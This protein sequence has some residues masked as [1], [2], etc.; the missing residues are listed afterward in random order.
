MRRERMRAGWVAPAALAAGVGLLAGCDKAEP[1]TEQA[2]GNPTGAAPDRVLA[3]NERPEPLERSTGGDSRLIR[4]IAADEWTLRLSRAPG[5][6]SEQE[7]E[8]VRGGN[9]YWSRIGSG[10]AIDPAELGADAS[11]SFRQGAD[12]TGDGRPN[13]LVR[14]RRRA[15]T[16]DLFLVLT[17]GD[18]V[19]V[20]ARIEAAGEGVGF[21]DRD[22][23][24]V[25]EFI[26]RDPALGEAS[27]A[28]VLAME[29]GEFRVSPAHMAA[30]APDRLEL[31]RR[32][33]RV[34]L[35]DAWEQGRPPASLREEAASLIY[36]GNEELAWRYLEWAWPEGIDGRDAYVEKLKADLQSSP[37]YGQL[38][39]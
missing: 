23:D 18:P 34:I 12:L 9:T 35:D 24:G 19:E 4:E 21:T 10:F 11:A 16:G 7:L 31:E 33:E 37:Y 26:T 39:R 17:P 36:S 28:I 20:V 6:G 32:I 8:V 38:G 30:P 29:D 5:G 1:E 27:P 15:G 2:T 22:G 25:L 13:L 14:E 3:T